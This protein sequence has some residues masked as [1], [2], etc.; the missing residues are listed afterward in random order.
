MVSVVPDYH[1]YMS[2]KGELG[3]AGQ[4]TLRDDMPHGNNEVLIR[5]AAAGVNRPDLMQRQGKYPPPPGASPIL[6]LE[7][8]GTVEEAGP[9]VARWKPGDRVCA[10]LA[11]GGYARFAVA[12]EEQVLPV[13]AGLDMIQAAALPETF[14]TVWTNMFQR[15][16][17]KRGET[18]L[19]HG[20]AS[21]IG[22]TAIQ[23][24]RAFGAR[25]F[26]T[27]GSPRKCQACRELG[28]EL[29]I[30]YRQSDFAEEVRKATDGRGVD[31]ILD[32]VGGPYFARN[33]ACLAMDGR[34]VQIAI[35]QGKQVE[36]DLLALMH[37]RATITG[38]TLRIR[39]PAEKGL[40]AREL[41]ARVWPLLERGEV[42]PVIDRV[43]PLDEAD[44][45][46]DYLERG[47]HIGKIVL[48]VQ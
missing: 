20:G 4:A 32:M 6:G 27:A 3:L 47:E 8:A 43:F 21:G 26:A 7:V 1:A 44:A 38:S 48:R 16:C 5:V 35:L 11:G 2:I 30:D 45:A 9:G 19:I 14:F 13:P 46:L 41:E 36:L 37:R 39:T 12:P 33:F 24:A 40:I 18:A 28:A 23:L 31:V 34:L 15:G 10:L 29:A 42:R 22:T 17:L 25:V